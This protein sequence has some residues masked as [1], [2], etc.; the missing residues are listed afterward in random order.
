MPK[1]KECNNVETFITHWRDITVT[2]YEGNEEI[3]SWSVGYEPTGESGEC[4]ECNSIEV[5]W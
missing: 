3:D 2:K 5:E 4:G 1:C